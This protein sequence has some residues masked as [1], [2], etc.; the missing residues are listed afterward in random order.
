MVDSA[1]MST[2]NVVTLC[3]AGDFTP[4]GEDLDR[5]ESRLLQLDPEVH[6]QVIAGEPERAA[7]LSST[8]V[9]FG[10]PDD[11]TIRAMPSLKW[12]QLPSAGAT[13]F[14]AN[15]LISGRVDVTTSS[16]VFGIAGAEHTLALLFAIARDMRW[17]VESTE[18]GRWGKHERSFE[19][20]GSTVGVFGLGSIGSETARRLTA[21]GASVIGVRR[22]ASGPAPD[23][24]E[25]L[26]GVEKA[27]DVLPRCD[28][29]VLAMPETAET[30]GFLSAERLAAL[31]PGV[32]IVNVG[33]G[34]A[35]DQDALVAALQSGHVAGAGLDVTTPEPLPP[36]DPLWRAPNVIV[37]SHSMNVFDR[38]DE[39]RFDLF[40]D[41]YARF[42]NGTALRNLVDHGRGY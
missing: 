23:Y 1:T 39:R 37:T 16:G 10:W 15:P 17:H 40:V 35:I 13:P 33:R 7:N 9:F 18:K 4:A 31:K 29:V 20:Y 41:N 28:A 25:E 27:D 14:V 12:V 22:N 36:E 32:L 5:L 11:E 21:L 26:V 34:S 42:L 38:K 6:L 19:V 24:V 2:R 3:T 30:R 8:T